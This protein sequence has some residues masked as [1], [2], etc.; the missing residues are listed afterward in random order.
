MPHEV[1]MPALGMAQDSGLIVAWHKAPGDEVAAGDVLFEVETDKSTVEVEA[2]QDGFVAALLAEAGEEAPVGEVIAVISKEKPQDPVQRSRNGGGAVSAPAAP[3]T[4]T[5]DP[6]PVPVTTSAPEPTRPAISA[7][8]RVLASPKAR[9]LALEQGLD[10]A[11]LVEAGHPQPYHVADLGLLRSLSTQTPEAAASARRLTAA[12]AQEGFSEFSAWAQEAAGLGDAA[13]LLA[14]FGGASL[15]RA[16]IV[17][18]E[19][20]SA[21]RLY[22]VPLGP[23]GD[24]TEA[25]PGSPPDLCLRDLRLSRISCVELGPENCPTLTLCAEGAGLVVTLE[26]AARSLS[27]REAV[28]LLSNFAA[29]MEQPVRHLL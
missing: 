18:V 4:K 15:G 7:D 5:A 24:V 8:G 26:C 23:L 9:R 29:R 22:Q 11:C 27:A 1:I 14:G 28:T 3:D 16:A 19:T 13:A 17:A 6:D 10:L 25:D 2:G 12:L 21:Q 20:L